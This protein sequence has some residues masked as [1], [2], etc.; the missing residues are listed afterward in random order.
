MINRTLAVLAMAAALQ[1]APVLAQAPDAKVAF[2]KTQQADD[3][4][5]SNII[6]EDVRN[7]S[8]EVIG[9]INDILF[10][11][12]GRIAA[13]VIGVGGFVGLGE[14]DVAVPY[15]S[16]AITAGKDG[17]RLITVNLT[18]S[19]LESAP[20]F[21]SRGAQK[22]GVTGKM[23]RELS[24]WGR[25]AQETAREV[26]EK[27][28]KAYSDAKRKAQETYSDVKKDMTEE[29]K[30]VTEEKKDLTGEPTEGESKSQ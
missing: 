20:E 13:V 3:W 18:K 21:E 22:G 27:A 30:D 7:R 2:V 10:A 4:L 9:D 23:Q 17:T 15:E 24:K 8:D 6:G 16:L 25:K 5:A 28:K 1:A 19:V 11:S 26:G 12:D 14:K 29:K